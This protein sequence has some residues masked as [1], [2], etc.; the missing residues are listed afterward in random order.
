MKKMLLAT[1]IALTLSAN[2]LADDIIIAGG[3]KGG[4]YDKVAKVLAKFLGNEFSEH[5]FKVVRTTGSEA[6]LKLID[7]SKADIGV[8][9]MDAYATWLGKASDGSSVVP[10]GP[11]Y[12]EC[13]F[14]AVNKKGKV[15]DE[16]DLQDAKGSVAIGEPGS[17]SV[18]TWEYMKTLE[19]GYGKAATA[20]VKPSKVLGQLAMNAANAPAQSVMWTSRCE[21][22]NTRYLKTVES[23]KSLRLIDVD[24]YDLND[25]HPS[26]GAPIY[27]FTK[28]K[29][30]GQKITTISMT[31]AVFA[32]DSLS[33]D[34]ADE[35]TDIVLRLK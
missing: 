28:V 10:V 5:S 13:V 27:E 23:Q 35:L 12:N 31:A 3:A 8:A 26:I 24:D 18:V 34:V 32:S 14:I 20:F 7:K 4:D 29:A 11:L 2:V 17:G 21:Q 25:N 22:P 6:N 30:A 16:D 33:E 1:T 9:Q 19:S 15:K